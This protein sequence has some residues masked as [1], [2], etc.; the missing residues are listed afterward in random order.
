VSAYVEVGSESVEAFVRDHGPGF[1]VDAVP[2]DRFGVRES[3]L[4]RMSRHGG[5]AALRQLEHGTEVFLSLPVI[6][7]SGPSSHA[8][9]PNGTLLCNGTLLPNPTRKERVHDRA[10]VPAGRLHPARPGR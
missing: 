5:S 3:I 9:L 2:Q 8:L 10:S 1:D 7:L 6:S 4:G